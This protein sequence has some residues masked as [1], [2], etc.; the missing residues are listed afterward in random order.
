MSW[1]KQGSQFTE[2][3]KGFAQGKAL[4]YQSAHINPENDTGVRMMEY[5]R[6][7]WSYFC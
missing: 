5:E 2:S 6:R 7:R 1:Q 4:S 3:S